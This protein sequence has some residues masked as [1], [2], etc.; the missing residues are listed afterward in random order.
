MS[1]Q[2]ITTTPTGKAATAVAAPPAPAAVPASP[3]PAPKPP[4]KPV[5]ADRRVALD[6]LFNWWVIG[7]ATFTA[8]MSVM[9]LYTLRF[10]MPNVLSEPSPKF[11]VGFPDTFEDGKVVERYKDQ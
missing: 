7:W 11:K 6:W 1:D 8:A 4:A 3:K 2:N 9:S 5:G 10:M